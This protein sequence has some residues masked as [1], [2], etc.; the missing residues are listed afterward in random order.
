MLVSGHVTIT[1]RKYNCRCFIISVQPSR[2][3]QLARDELPRCQI[4]A[5][6]AL[7]KL[8]GALSV[9]TRS[10]DVTKKGQRS[11]ACFQP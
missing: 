7:K 10:C 2:A 6:S 11:G 5:Y 4:T 8:S 9:A 1:A 3:E